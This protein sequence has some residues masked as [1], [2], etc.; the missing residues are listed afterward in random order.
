MSAIGKRFPALCV[1]CGLA[2]IGPAA[3]AAEI[4][5]EALARAR[6]AN[7]AQDFATSLAIYR[8]W[9]Q[10]G[11]GAATTA[12]G[13]MYWSGAGVVKDHQR[14]CDLFAEAEKRSDPNGTELFGD[15]YFH[16]DGR[17][18][19]YSQSAALYTRASERG[20]AQ[21][22]CAL[23]N[24]YLLGFGVTKDPVKA[25]SLC[26][27][28]AER[29][30]ADAQT[31]LGQMY[32]SGTGVERSP[33]QAARW[34][35]KAMD[36]GQD[37][38]NAALLLGKMR[39]NGDGVERNH[40]LAASAW[41]VAAQHGNR[42]APVLLAKYYFAASIA[43]PNQIRVEPGTKAIYWATVATH[44][45]ADPAARQESQK[46]LDMLLRSAPSL[47]ARADDMLASRTIP[48]L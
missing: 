21:A 4:E 26:R 11:S 47:K 2:T 3:S 37:N 10:R 36:Q 29:G 45:E 15:C 17:P 32:L 1:L 41:L 38:G 14:A 9:S 44:V 13:L 30:V 34:F 7:Q 31:D 42:S 27:K 43:E 16:G 23:G 48:P 6:T 33:E 39:W 5:S 20:V 22:D 40:D 28:G 19:D 18:Q 24:Q 8:E 35:Q 25:F 12:L 46:L